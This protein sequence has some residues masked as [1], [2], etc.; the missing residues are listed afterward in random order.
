MGRGTFLKSISKKKQPDDTHQSYPFH[1]FIRCSYAFLVACFFIYGLFPEQKVH[2]ECLTDYDRRIYAIENELVRAMIPNVWN[3]IYAPQIVS[4]SMSLYKLKKARDLISEANT[5]A[6]K[7]LQEAFCDLKGKKHDVHGYFE[8]PEEDFS[9]LKLEELA[10]M[11]RTANQLQFFC[12]MSKPMK[13][14]KIL[15]Y[16]RSGELKSFID[17]NADHGFQKLSED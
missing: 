4:D 17:M 3:I 10:Q 9:Q 16:L 12:K 14:S 11:I 6:G 8:V 1:F 13:Y 7:T 5:G 15:R 2:A